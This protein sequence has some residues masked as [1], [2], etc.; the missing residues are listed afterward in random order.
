MFIGAVPPG[1]VRTD[2]RGAIAD[3]TELTVR[4]VFKF[5]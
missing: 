2:D 1:N 5:R 3:V 4:S